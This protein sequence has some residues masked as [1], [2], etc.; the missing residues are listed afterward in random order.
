MNFKKIFAG[1]TIC[2][3]FTLALT[4]CSDIVYPPRGIDPDTIGTETL[5]PPPP[6]LEPIEDRYRLLRY[7]ITPT[8][9]EYLYDFNEPYLISAHGGEREFSVTLEL[10]A[11]QHYR[12]GINTRA[13]AGSPI[14]QLSSRDEIFGVFFV[15]G[16]YALEEES[17]EYFMSPIYLPE[18]ETTLTFTA[19]RGAVAIDSIIANDVL[20]IPNSRFA[21]TQSLI[22][23]S[24]SAEA[25]ELLAFLNSIYGSRV[26]T[27]QRVST[28]T[29]AEI[30]ALYTATFRK[31]AVRF[32]ELR[33]ATII[34]NEFETEFGAFQTE[35]DLALDWHQ[36][37]G[38]VG[39]SWTWDS[40]CGSDS[41][42]ADDSTFSLTAALVGAEESGAVMLDLDFVQTLTETEE[43]TPELILLIRDIDKIAEVFN[44]FR[45]AGVPVL[46]NP[47]PDAGSGLYWWSENA[48]SYLRLWQFMY[49]RLVNFHGLNN[50]VWVWSGGSHQFYP[51]DN[52]V[53]IIAE[54]MFG[55]LN[56]NVDSG[57]LNTLET[58][59]SSMNTGSVRFSQTADY[60][61]LTNSDSTTENFA[62]VV[63]SEGIP[64]PDALVRDNAMWLIWG[65]ER[66]GFAINE[67]GE[68]LPELLNALDQFYNHEITITLDQL[69]E[70][71]S[72]SQTT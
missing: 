60:N 58:A 39:Y 47:L 51:G 8:P 46:F 35:K 37:G 71:L 40:P 41:A 67:N 19:L 7:D 69:S 15:E 44:R 56:R 64:S 63:R 29:N 5:A 20:S 49:T 24:P 72:Y 50:L 17:G 43:I 32:G 54:S 21:N 68:I 53:D 18:G 57:N 2:M 12:I 38:I 9:F 62:M 33:T 26:L 1:A 52:R 3:L 13:P 36:K 14:I 61:N 6:A 65:L 48:E 22:T 59:H 23:P 45:D 27:S 30:E 11:P 25:S 31:P 66:G 28:G 55:V 42:F 34:S 4:A 70:L 16:L 10:N